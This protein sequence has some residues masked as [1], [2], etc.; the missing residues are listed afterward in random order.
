MSRILIIFGTMLIL[1]GV[2]WPLL[3]KFGIGH[4]PG[5]IMF[6]RGEITFYF[7]I[8]T[9]IIISLVFTVIMWLFNR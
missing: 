8:S 9:C 4:L 2:L 3:K 6:K 5:D 1:L 7:P